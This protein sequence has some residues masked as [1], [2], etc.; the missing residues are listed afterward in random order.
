MNLITKKIGNGEY[1]YLVFR[2]GKKIV[3]K[4]L[5][6]VNNPQVIKLTTG[7]K[8]VSIIPKWLQYLFWDTSLNKIH[9]KQNARYIIER[10]LEFGDMYALEWLQRVYPTRTIIDVIFLSRN[11]T[12]KSR[13]FWRLWF[14]ITDV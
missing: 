1:A 6:S 14:G 13:N 9:I 3:H 2:E 10:V 4:Y 12:E 5:G 8:D 7:K 11:L